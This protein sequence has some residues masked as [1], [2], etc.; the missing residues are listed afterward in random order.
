MPPVAVLPLGS[1]SATTDI[2]VLDRDSDD[3]LITDLEDMYIELKPFSDEDDLELIGSRNNIA[4]N[5]S[6]FYERMPIPDLQVPDKSP[7]GER[8]SWVPTVAVEEFA[9]TLT[10][11]FGLN[12]TQ[13]HDVFPKLHRFNNQDLDFYA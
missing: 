6:R 7:F 3:D 8:A 1:C 2:E 11:W 13:L 10:S 12:N 5:G 4:V 9:A